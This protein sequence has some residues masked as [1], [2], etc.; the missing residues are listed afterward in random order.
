MLLARSSTYHGH[1]EI[2][3]NKDDYFDTENHVKLFDVSWE[4]R[5]SEIPFDVKKEINY[6][7]FGGF[8]VVVTIERDGEDI[9]FTRLSEDVKHHWKTTSMHSVDYFLLNCDLNFLY[10][11]LD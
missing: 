5:K 10:D 11:V 3:T 9:Y 8:I 4:Y 7:P 1:W 6:I 2:T